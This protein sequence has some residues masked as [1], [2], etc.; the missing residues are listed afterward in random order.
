MRKLISTLLLSIVI[1]ISLKASSNEVT[2]IGNSHGFKTGELIIMAE[3]WHTVQIE[4]DKFKITIPLKSN[5]QKI[6]LCALKLKSFL[7]FYAE[8]GIINA[9]VYKKG[10]LKNTHFTGSSSQKIMNEFEDAIKADSLKKFHDLLS[11]NINTLPGVD[12]L[13][14]YKKRFTIDKV[15]ELYSMIKEPLKENAED[16]KAYVDTYHIE[17]MEKGAKAFNFKWRQDV[18]TFNLSDFKGKYV[19]L[20]F[21]ATACSPC[22][23][24]Y[25]GMNELEDL[26]GNSIKVISFHVGN[27]KKEW[28]E[29]AKRKNVE[30]KCTSLWEVDKKKDV[31]TVYKIS[32]LPTF[33]LLDK[34]GIIIDRWVGRLHTKKI[35]NQ[36]K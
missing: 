3:E 7:P 9:E 31:L 22:W 21:T 5:P 25:E 12:Y 16:I 20:N 4:N 28:Y 1:S 33:V 11:L 14:M 13:V 27:T 30:F 24:A 2:I 10:F 8:N 6:K 35:L 17:A 23:K 29:I 15:R 32:I 36:I 18:Q 26:H 34:N 19:L